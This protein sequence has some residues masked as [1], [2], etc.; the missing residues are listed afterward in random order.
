[1]SSDSVPCSWKDG[2][3]DEEIFWARYI[4]TRGLEWTE[5]Y[6]KRIDPVSELQP[7]ISEELRVT[8]GRIPV[9]LDVG[10]GPMSILGKTWRGEPITL[11]AVD[12]LAES[13][14]RLLAQSGVTPPVRTITGHVER[15]GDSF[16]PDFFD[17]VHM[18][19]ALDHS[20]DPLEGI[21]QML[22]V[23]KVG[24]PVM[25]WHFRNEAEREN[26]V[27]FH[28]WNVDERNGRM[29]LWNKLTTLDVAVELGGSVELIVD[30]SETTVG[31]KLRKSS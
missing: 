20:Y 8:A 29:V 11:I 27:G 12:P 14:D 19:N 6:Q 9:I 5:E 18:R 17:L 30:G 3:A 23:A 25:L 10:A 15:L 2:K 4:E 7:Y 21:R 28:Q 31:C 13:Y 22:N 26:Y 16:E 24:A 1:M